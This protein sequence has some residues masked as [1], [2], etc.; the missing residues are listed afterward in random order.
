MISFCEVLEKMLVIVVLLVRNSL[1]REN[2]FFF[3]YFV[4]N[5]CGLLVSIVSEFIV[6]VLGF[7]VDG[8]NFFYFVKVS[9]N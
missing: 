1:R 6:L 9:V 5:I 8:F 3:F 2:E 7:E 4:L